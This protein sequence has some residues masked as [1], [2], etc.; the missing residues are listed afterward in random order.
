[1]VEI[2]PLED[3]ISFDPMEN[4]SPVAVE[5]DPRRKVRSAAEPMM[6]SLSTTQSDPN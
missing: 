2:V 6:N 4:T 5:M 3:Q 1:M